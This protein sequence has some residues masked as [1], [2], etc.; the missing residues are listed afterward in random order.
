MILWAAMALAPVAALAAQSADTVKVIDNPGRVIVTEDASDMKFTVETK[1]GAIYEIKKKKASAAQSKASANDDDGLRVT[2]GERDTTKNARVNFV[3]GGFYFG[4]GAAKAHGDA[5]G[6]LANAL[7]HTSEIGILNVAGVGISTRCGF[8]ASL[9]VGFNSR[10]YNLHHGTCFVKD[11]AGL[12][13]I[14][15]KDETWTKA[16][17]SLWVGSLQFPLLLKQRIWRNLKLGVGVVMDLNL[18]AQ[19]ENHY[20]IGDHNYTD[21]I[22][23]V[24]QRKVTFSPMA[25]LNYEP[26][27]I[28]F[29]Y[30][31]QKVLK[32]DLGPQF[33]N[34]TLG[35][36]LFF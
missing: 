32:S 27:G 13:A 14:A 24:H 6:Q 5:S 19:A 17:S 9:G 36:M 15:D 16:K 28:Y 26:I 29:R 30:Y 4:W 2:F 7:G 10:N 34:W 21:K 33:N 18:W 11:E 31:P 3:F 20:T 12:L 8:S 23:N 22:K 35:V 1:D 25:V